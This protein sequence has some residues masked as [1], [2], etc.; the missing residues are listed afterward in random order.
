M[1]T[2]PAQM[3]NS[4]VQ[5]ICLAILSI[6]AVATALYF[7][8]PVMIPFVLAAVIGLILTPLIDSQMR[9]LKFPH[10]LALTTTMLVSLVITFAFWLIAVHSFNQITSNLDSYQENIA[11]LISR[12]IQTIPLEKFGLDPG[13]IINPAIQKMSEGAGG[14][15]MG[16]VSTVVRLFS[17]AVLVVI[18]LM[19]LLLGR[20]PRE[21]ALP[22]NSLMAEIEKSVK[23]YLITKVF[24][25]AITGVLVG[26]ILLFLGV[27]LALAFGL[28]AF[29]LNFIP[30][31]G[32]IIATLLP[33]PFVIIN[34]E[35]SALKS[36]LAI[37]L[38]GIVQ[39]SIGN[40][41]EPK[42]MGESLDLHPVVI[43]MALIFW[44]MIW[45][46]VGMLLA[47]PLT[48]IMKI[49]FGKIE[50]TRPLANILAGRLDYL[51]N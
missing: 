21:K 43:L 40:I 2:T 30:S 9:F 7:L 33:L 13:N 49:I 47:A 23:K 41:I 10:K 16:T 3:A 24:T 35:F 34:P 25:S 22:Q 45:G 5:T 44:G 19:F 38:P 6:I 14:F 36:I 27:D 26:L 28:C 20:Q 29:I 51:E 8:R 1:T 4:R 42:I 37:G 15:V 11:S 39:F 18:F 48:A 50:V 12:T 32:S 46:I 31:I 17:K